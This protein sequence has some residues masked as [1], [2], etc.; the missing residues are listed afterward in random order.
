[1]DRRS[2]HAFPVCLALVAIASFA[3]CGGGTSTP[4]KQPGFPVQ[5]RDVANAC[6]EPRPASITDAGAPGA[7]AGMLQGNCRTDADCTQGM[8][9]RCMPPTGNAAGDY[10]TYDACVVDGDCAS[11][12]ACVCDPR[13][14]R[15]GDSSC[16][17]DADCNGRGCSPSTTGGCGGASV[18]GYYCHTTADECIDDKDCSDANASVC[19]YDP[20]LSH[21]ACAQLVICAG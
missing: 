8:S 10:C 3:A 12:K 2:I 18:S 15:C 19:Q 7:D 14:N 16:R 1:M 9:G 13:G 4:A 17:T 5:H 20:Q 11:G 6:P 21:W